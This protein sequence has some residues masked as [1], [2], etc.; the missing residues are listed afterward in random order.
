MKTRNNQQYKNR[1]MIFS[2]TIDPDLVAK[3]M[4]YDDNFSRFTRD[5]IEQKIKF[6]ESQKKK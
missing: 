1:K 2:I 4:E 5:A 3:A 6:I